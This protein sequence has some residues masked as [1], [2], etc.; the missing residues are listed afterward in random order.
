[1]SLTVIIQLSISSSTFCIVKQFFSPHPLVFNIAYSTLLVYKFALIFYYDVNDEIIICFIYSNAKCH[2]DGILWYYV[3]GITELSTLGYLQEILASGQLASS[4]WLC[5]VIN[6]RH[7]VRNAQVW[8]TEYWKNIFPYCL[9]FSYRS[10]P[11]CYTATIRTDTQNQKFS[12]N[13][14]TKMAAI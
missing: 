10:I 11:L 2:L 9:L 3:Q 1:M 5:I 6:V 14:T 7:S 12:K 8:N 4:K 13:I